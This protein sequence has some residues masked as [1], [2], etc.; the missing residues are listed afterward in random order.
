[1]KIHLV[2]HTPNP[3]K[4]IAAAFF[5]MGIGM[6]TQNLSQISD[7]Q[8][9]DALE[10]IE[11][12][13]LTAP[14]EYASFNFFWEDIPL[15]MRAHLVRHR[16]GWSF[17]ER[18]LRF[19]DANLQDPCKDYDWD[20]M[21][22]IKDKPAKSP[23]LGG[24]SIKSLCEREMQRQMT[25]YSLLVEEGVDQQDARNFIAVWYPT[26]MQTA[27]TFRALRETMA[28]RLS[29]QAHPFWQKAARQIKELVT[30]VSPKLGSMLVD[31]CVLAGRCVW[32]SRF[33]RECPDCVA[34][35]K[36]KPHVHIWS[37]DT[38]FGPN[39]QCDCGIMRTKQITEKAKD[40]GVVYDA[41]VV[42]VQS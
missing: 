11:K 22:T 7:A 28:D 18:S 36:S 42:E 3:E 41:E 37:R 32:Q 12:T 26:A 9:L 5:N 34:R 30:Q 31:R 16:V 4:A 33:D 13:H 17:A 24:Q 2:S 40:D 6:D 38:S 8:A 27:V 15:F 29:A 25:F 14:L 19:F 21:P 10:E 1:M 23:V 35:G 39:T 20:A